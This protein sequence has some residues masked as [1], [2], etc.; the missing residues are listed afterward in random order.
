MSI[1]SSFNGCEFYVRSITDQGYN[2][3][4][5]LHDIV[6]GKYGPY[7]EVM[8]R[9][10]EIYEIEGFVSYNSGTYFDSNLLRAQM[11]KSKTGLFMHPSLGLKTCAV[12]G[13]G[14]SED[15]MR[16]G[17][18]EIRLSLV[19]VNNKSYSVGTS[20]TGTLSSLVQRATN[21]LGS[22]DLQGIGTTALSV[23]GAGEGIIKSISGFDPVLS[24]IGQTL[25]RFY[26]AGNMGA[27]ILNEAG[28]L[29]DALPLV[30]AKISDVTKSL[31]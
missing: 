25:G 11:M 9:G 3:Q 17:V 28:T 13:I 18:C 23:M 20:Q 24:E 12:L 19:V 10:P 26:Q 6:N 7:V 1:I 8:G 4:V 15:A 27:S 21:V 14:M 22:V 2:N 16:K 5:V 29:G 31:T 30:E